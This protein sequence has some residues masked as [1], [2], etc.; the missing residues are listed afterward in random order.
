MLNDVWVYHVS[1]A[2]WREVEFS[3]KHAVPPPRIE[4]AQAKGDWEDGV[5]LMGFGQDPRRGKLNVGFGRCWYMFTVIWIP[6]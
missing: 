6:Y 4:A 5:M 3:K 1:H 2:L